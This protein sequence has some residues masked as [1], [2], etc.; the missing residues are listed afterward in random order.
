MGLPMARNLQRKGFSVKIVGHL[1]REPV[2]S[3]KREGAEEVNSPREL[4]RECNVI[5]SMVSNVEQME[6]VVF[7]EAGAHHE[8]NTHCPKRRR[9]TAGAHNTHNTPND[10]L[11]TLVCCICEL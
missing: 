5:F 11:Q 1:R 10:D 7:E 9:M 3:M 4:V 8:T 2:E 6:E